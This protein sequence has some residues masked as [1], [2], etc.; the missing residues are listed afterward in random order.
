M[1]DLAKLVVRMEAQTAKFQKDLSRAEKRI[2]RFKKAAKKDFGA[3]QIAAGALA[4]GAITKQVVD[5]TIKQEQAYKQLVQGIES[6]N[7]A[8]GFS[9]Q[10][11][12]QYAEE[13]Q[14]AT[15]FGDED[16]IK[17]QSQLV[18]FTKITGEE[19]KKT[20]EL[21][22]D[23]AARFDTDLKS[24]TIQLGKA[25]NDPV[26]NLSAL[27]RAG[28]QFS[29]EQKDFI[30]SL[31]DSGN[32]VG[33]Q[34]VILS[35]LET[36]F[37][38]SAK[39]ARDTFGGALQALSN[40]FGDLLESDTGLSAAKQ[41]ME[42]LNTL[43]SD[44]KTKQ[45]AQDFTRALIGGMS[46]AVRLVSEFK[47]FAVW[48][49]ESGARTQ[50]FADSAM[51][52]QE[53][54]N[55]ISE[56]LD[57]VT[58]QIQEVQNDPSWVIT[59]F[60]D[61]DETIEQLMIK[62]EGLNLEL[63]AAKEKFKAL[64]EIE[65]DDLP[66]PPVITEPATK[67]TSQNSTVS[68]VDDSLVSRAAALVNEVTPQIDKLQ[69]K[70]VESAQLFQD[71]YLNQEQ[72]AQI[73]ETYGQQIAAIENM[74]Q[75]AFDE[76]LLSLEEQFLT[77]NELLLAQQE[78]RLAFIQDGLDKGL[79]SEQDAAMKR[80]QINKDYHK[81]K[82]ELDKAAAQAEMKQALTVAT[83]VLQIMSAFAGKSVKAQ[84]ALAIA[85]GVINIT[86]GVTKALNN[87]FPENLGFAAQVAAQGAALISTIKGVSLGSTATPG[88][89]A[90]GGSLAT[91]SAVG[92]IADNSRLE[93]DEN[94]KKEAKVYYV[95]NGDVVTENAGEWLGERLK[96][97]INNSDF[98]L[99]DPSS[100]NGQDLAAAGGVI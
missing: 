23:M 35:E 1:A 98:V 34:K 7:K 48:V 84:K 86:A 82:E 88:L 60:G 27:S 59:L 13:L 54:I 12:A 85:E 36:Q 52:A 6:T 95:F 32:A 55:K 39:A 94:A 8:V 42:K 26:A 91:P 18:T 57:N 99:V 29:K 41:E 20:T 45:A 72:F 77:E 19:F 44:P 76:K 22:L 62:W 49:G 33:A 38:G 75:L 81:N 65:A 9:A 92:D 10:E 74:E 83:G 28:I 4:L 71:K 61:Q 24:A 47:D 43:L 53:Q 50:G 58:S 3:V 89:S 69:A 96:D 97:S 5:A 78:E 87:P 79:I 51:D 21:A 17:A 80:L 16:I 56:E 90:S 11:L 93:V 15:T 37:G 63:E 2:E 30:K 40:S 68:S 14:K 64:S 25:L 31:V 100:R 46:D 73:V 67:T 70:I 66:A